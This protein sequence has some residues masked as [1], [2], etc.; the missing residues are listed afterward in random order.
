MT[1][2]YKAKSLHRITDVEFYG[3]N[4]DTF[5][6]L[7]EQLQQGSPDSLSL[8]KGKVSIDTEGRE[9]EILFTSIPYD[10]GWKIKMNGDQITPV[11]FENCLICIPLEDGENRIQMSYTAP[12]LPAG[13]M[14]SVLGICAL[15]ATAVLR[16]R[17]YSSK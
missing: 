3:L 8:G 10:E 13:I 14:L 1:V 2:K 5:R 12:G 15:A 17:L 6:E 16:K 4:L 9:G 11:L 7:T